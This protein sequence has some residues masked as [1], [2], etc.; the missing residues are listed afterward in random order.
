MH[1]AHEIY[2]AFS[3]D[4]K[5]LAF[6]S[7]RHGSYDVFVVSVRGG[8]PRRL[9]FDSAADFVAGWSPDERGRRVW[10]RPACLLVLADGSLLISDDGNGKIYRVTY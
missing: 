2:P 9:T 5:W 6:S 8:R 10:G 7:D 3:P 1:E 4:G